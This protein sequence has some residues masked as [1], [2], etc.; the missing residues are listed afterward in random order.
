MVGAH[1]AFLKTRCRH[2][3]EKTMDAANLETQPV[4]R[5]WRLLIVDDEDFVRR[6]IQRSLRKEG[7]EIATAENGEEALTVL[8]RQPMDIV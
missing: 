6:A 5:P 2:N 7:F 4:N 3:L 8:Q 1:F